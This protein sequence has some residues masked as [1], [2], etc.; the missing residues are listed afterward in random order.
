MSEFDIIADLEVEKERM[1]Q[2][3]AE[4]E[5]SHETLIGQ[6]NR[7]AERLAQAERE[8]DEAL[9]LAEWAAAQLG[10]RTSPIAW[11]RAHSGI[12]AEEPTR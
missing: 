6:T 9:A 3:I 8:R 7:L 10:C 4:L 2:R 12:K 5:A 11:L 1:R